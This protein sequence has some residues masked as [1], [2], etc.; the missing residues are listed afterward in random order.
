MAENRFVSLSKGF[1]KDSGLDIHVL[2]DRNTGV[3]YILANN[4]YGC[5]LIP[6]LGSDGKV[7]SKD[8]ERAI[9]NLERNR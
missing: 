5:Q 3:N 2:M 8:P 7:Y 9:N 4:E 6:L 1:N